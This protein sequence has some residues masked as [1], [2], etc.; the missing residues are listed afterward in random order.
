MAFEGF[1]LDVFYKDSSGWD[2]TFLLVVDSAHS[3]WESYDA[4]LSAY[5]KGKHKPPGIDTPFGITGTAFY[6]AAGD[7]LYFALSDFLPIPYYAGKYKAGSR[8]TGKF[9]NAPSVYATALPDL[10]WA[11]GGKI[12]SLSDAFG[13]QTD[14]LDG[15]DQ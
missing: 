14:S 15:G 9:I 7:V 2:R 8:G 13:T 4:R 11:F 5:G 1:Q 12:F 6:N 3:T 10:K